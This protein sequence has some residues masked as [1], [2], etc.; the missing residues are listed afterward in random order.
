MRDQRG[1]GGLLGVKKVGSKRTDKGRP[2]GLCRPAPRAA[3]QPL[4][5]GGKF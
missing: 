3:W 5:A 1:H 4:R 2:V